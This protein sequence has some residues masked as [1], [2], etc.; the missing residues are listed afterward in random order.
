MLGHNSE[1][2]S[3]DI[4]S[5]KTLLSVLVQWTIDKPGVQKL[6]ETFYV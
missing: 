6:A 2:K 5:S 1:M 3:V 4:V